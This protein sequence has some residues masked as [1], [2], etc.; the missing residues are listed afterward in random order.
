MIRVHEALHLLDSLVSDK[1]LMSLVI[2]EEI[3]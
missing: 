1:D 3:D 2:L